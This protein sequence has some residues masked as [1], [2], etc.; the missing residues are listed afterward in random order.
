M[1]KWAFFVFVAVSCVGAT[2]IS[3]SSQTASEEVVPRLRLDEY[4]Q[5]QQIITVILNEKGLE[6]AFSYVSQRASSSPSFVRE[7]H[8]LMH[9]LGHEAYHSFNE[10]ISQALAGADEMCNSGYTHGV[11]QSFF[12]HMPNSDLSAEQICSVEMKPSYDFWQ[13]YH[14][15]GHGYMI[16]TNRNIDD[17][18]IKCSHI[19]NAEAE[20]ACINGSFMEAFFLT[21]HSYELVRSL[22]NVNLSLCLNR[23]HKNHCYLYAPTAYLEANNNDYRG[24]IYNYCSNAERRYIATCHFGVGSQAM[25]ENRLKPK[26]AVGVCR[27]FELNIAA[28]CLAGAASS[29]FFNVGTTKNASLLCPIIFG[30]HNDIC[31]DEAQTIKT[32]FG[33]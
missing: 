2:F 33:F 1:K 27:E 21:D 18:L 14:G 12:K 24:A 9:Y 5:E 3:A 11:V 31:L 10:S 19:N 15:L 25:K 29:Y 30:E 32:R 23:E 16:A 28:N 26:V 4:L 17:S 20:D 22:D 7:C 13:C 8:P 6:E